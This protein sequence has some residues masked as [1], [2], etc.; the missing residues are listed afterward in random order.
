MSLEQKCSLLELSSKF[1]SQNKQRKQ[2]S[3][4]HQVEQSIMLLLIAWFGSKCFS[5]LIL[6]NTNGSK[7]APIW[8]PILCSFHSTYALS[9]NWFQRLL[10]VI[11]IWYF[12]IRKFPGQTEPTL[13]AEV[14]LI[15][16]IAEK[17]SWT[18]PPI[19]MEFQVPKLITIYCLIMFNSFCSVLMQY[20][21]L[22]NIENYCCTWNYSPRFVIIEMLY[23]FTYF[24]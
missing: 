12:R 24:L 8:L 9:L 20:L 19:Q 11:F 15:S 5:L 4:S 18:R 13:S 16:T 1:L 6:L 23:L 2:V 14:E 17:K 3:K 7:P 21:F 22:E 10:K